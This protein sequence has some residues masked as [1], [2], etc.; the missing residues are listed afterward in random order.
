LEELVR[1]TGNSIEDPS[2]AEFINNSQ[3]RKRPKTA[4][5][6]FFAEYR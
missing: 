2:L 4:F 1:R 6:L 5:L 3:E